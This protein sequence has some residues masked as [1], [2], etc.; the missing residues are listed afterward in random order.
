M[1]RVWTCTGGWAFCPFATR[2][3]ARAKEH[4]ALPGH[5]VIEEDVPGEWPLSGVQLDSLR[6]E[7]ESG[8]PEA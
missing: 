1:S 7:R 2:N 8:E 6:R 3:E 5:S 4:D